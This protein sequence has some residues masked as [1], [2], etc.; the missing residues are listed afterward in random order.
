[1]RTTVRAKSHLS[2]QNPHLYLYPEM[3]DELIKYVF[4]PRKLVDGYRTHLAAIQ[5][6]TKPRP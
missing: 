6:G 4:I 5:A 2:A 1:M 3:L